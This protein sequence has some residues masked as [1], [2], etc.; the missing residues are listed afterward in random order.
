LYYN[1]PNCG[2]ELLKSYPNNKH[3]LRTNIVIFENG[4]AFC[5]CQKCHSDVAIPIVL[6]LP[7]SNKIKYYVLDEE[8]NKNSKCDVNKMKVEK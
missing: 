6:K 1:C 7:T 3:K 5:K 2:N 8:V 4:K